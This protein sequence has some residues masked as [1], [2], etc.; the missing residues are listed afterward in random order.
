MSK[1]HGQ[2]DA[3]YELRLHYGPLSEDTISGMFDVIMGEG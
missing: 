1:V 2:C 3:G